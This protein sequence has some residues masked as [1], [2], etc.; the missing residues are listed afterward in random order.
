MRN[1]LL[2]GWNKIRPVCGKQRRK[3]GKGS[4]AEKEFEER[5]KWEEA[6]DNILKW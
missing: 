2:E 1:I 3:R 5:D 6:S 4:C